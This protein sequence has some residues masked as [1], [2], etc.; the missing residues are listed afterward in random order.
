MSNLQIS[1]FFCSPP[2]H[3]LLAIGMNRGGWQEGPKRS[4]QIRGK[5]YKSIVC[6][7]RKALFQDI[8]Y[9]FADLP[10]A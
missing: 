7:D 2:L 8:C 5:E 10:C 4:T 9:S 3:S 1:N 6:R